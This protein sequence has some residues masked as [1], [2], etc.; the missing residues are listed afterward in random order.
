ML[1]RE[2]FTSQR[3]KVRERESERE[4]ERWRD[5]KRE[6]E[7]ERLN[8]YACKGVHTLLTDQRESKRKGERERKRGGGERCRIWLFLFLKGMTGAL[9]PFSYLV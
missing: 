5:R 8:C 1:A 4:K 3:D 7:R 6:G 9:A 2:H